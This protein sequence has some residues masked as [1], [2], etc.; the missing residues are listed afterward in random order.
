[1]R[2]LQLTSKTSLVVG[3]AGDREEA[4]LEV[5]RQQ[6]T[7]LQVLDRLPLG[8]QHAL[9]FLDDFVATGQEQLEKLDVRLKR[10]WDKR[11]CGWPLFRRREW[12]ATF[13]PSQCVFNSHAAPQASV[14]EYR[15]QRAERHIRTTGCWL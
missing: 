2:F 6:A 13:R 4:I 5:T 8:V 7:V 10:H 3:D 14:F 11:G 9:Y 15:T 1:M 12:F